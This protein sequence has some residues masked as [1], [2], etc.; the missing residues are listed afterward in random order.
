MN[1][2]PRSPYVR[3]PSIPKAAVPKLPRLSMSMGNVSAPKVGAMPKLTMPKSP[4]AGS[5]K[6]TAGNFTGP[7]ASQ[8][9]SASLF[10]SAQPKKM[11]IVKGAIAK[12]KI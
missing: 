7:T 3:M 6:S 10:K 4:V 5:I 2:F 8:K 12:L 9:A 11:A 1:L